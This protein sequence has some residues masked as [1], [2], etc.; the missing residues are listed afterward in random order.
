MVNMY[1]ACQCAGLHGFNLSLH[2]VAPNHENR[3]AMPIYCRFYF[4]NG[5]C[6]QN[7]LRFKCKSQ[8]ITFGSMICKLI[9][10][11]LH[12][13]LHLLPM[14]QKPII[15]RLISYCARAFVHSYDYYYYI[16]FRIAISV[17][18]ILATWALFKQ[19]QWNE[20]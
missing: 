4:R 10:Y 6:R 13:I 18:Q 2:V 14:Q 7:A 19:E 3:I 1:H 8:W 9:Y 16:V 17:L 15:D 11:C 12:N 5:A 20:I